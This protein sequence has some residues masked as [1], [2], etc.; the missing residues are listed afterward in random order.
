MLE[1]KKCLATFHVSVRGGAWRRRHDADRF[2]TL[3]STAGPSPHA[4]AVQP[5]HKGKLCMHIMRIMC[6]T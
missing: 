5:C 3:I 6:G 4:D 2:F 1:R